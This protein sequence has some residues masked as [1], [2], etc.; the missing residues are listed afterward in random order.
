[1]TAPRNGRASLSS[2][3]QKA[4]REVPSFRHSSSNVSTFADGFCGD[5][6]ANDE[7]E[8]GNDDDDDDDDDDDENKD[9]ED[10]AEEYQYSL[11]CSS[12]S[13]AIFGC[14]ARHAFTAPSS[15]QK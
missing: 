4:H 10:E 9:E 5:D 1:M 6:N 15:V 8:G 12:S 2:S 11:R 13:R 3:K 7:D 14:S